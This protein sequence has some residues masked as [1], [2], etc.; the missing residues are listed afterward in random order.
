MISLF[1][2]PREILLAIP[3][4]IIGLIFHEF[5][6]ALMA[7]LLGDS[8][9]R[10]YGRLTL[11]PL[12]HVDIIGLL[13]FVLIGFGWARPVPVNPS[14]FKRPRLYDILVSLAGPV[15]NFL[16]ALITLLIEFLIFKIAGGTYNVLPG[17][18]PVFS[19]I[20]YFNIAFFFLN[21]LPIPPLDGYHILRSFV[22]NRFGNFF[23]F[24][25]RYGILFLIGFIFFVGPYFFQFAQNFYTSLF[26]IFSPF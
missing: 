13:A 21:L 4:V 14:N 26:N 6:H 25:E 8:T 24:Y 2:D 23:G 5:S 20:A 22:G 3:A 17:L 18:I 15:S 1:R 9:P 10:R 7:D 12:A 11:N 16:I 19:Y